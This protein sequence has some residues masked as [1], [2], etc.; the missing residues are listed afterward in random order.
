MQKVK[1]SMVE[2][3]SGESLEAV[4]ASIPLAISY[5]AAA[6]NTAVHNTDRLNAALQEELVQRSGF[7]IVSPGISYVESSLVIP[8]EVTLLIF[9]STGKL[10]LLTASF[11]QTPLARGGL[12]IKQKGSTGITL[13]A[14][15]NGVSSDPI[16]Q[17]VD[18]ANGDVAALQTKYVE[19]DEVTDPAAPSANKARLYVKDD[20]TGDT[21]LAVRF[22]SG[23]PLIIK[24]QGEVTPVTELNAEITYNVGSL[25]ANARE[26]TTLTVTGAEF[27]DFVQVSSTIDTGGIRPIGHVSAAN[28]VT[29]TFYNLSG[30]TVDLAS[31]TYYVRVF[32][33]TY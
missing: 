4:L 17:L 27:G 3:S 2:L 6:G 7:L 9:D 22:A 28:T 11:G 15:D 25:N 1:G 30:G 23:S 14:V 12:A 19:L 8:D 18:L 10:T 29:L 33:R 5:G 13:R 31:A 20:G 21:Q 16:L 26:T 24:T 32:K